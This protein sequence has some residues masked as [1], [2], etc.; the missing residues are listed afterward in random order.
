MKKGAEVKVKVI[1]LDPEGRRINLSLKHFTE[2]PWLRFEEDFHVNDIVRGKVTKLTDFGA[3]IEL[4]EGIEGLAHVSE[5]SWTKKIAN[6][7]DVLKIGDEVDC[8]IL[9]YDIA[10]GRVSLGLKQVTENPWD[11]FAE[12]SP[13]GT[14]LTGT[15]VKLTASGAYVKL[16]CGL[17]A[18][19]HAD[20]YSWTRRLKNL[21]GV[22]NVGDEIETVVLDFDRESRRIRVGVKQLSPDP[23]KAF[24]EAHQPGDSVEGEITSI[25]DFGVFLKVDGDIEGLINKDEYEAHI[26]EHRCPAGV[27]TALTRFEINPDKQKVSF[28]VREYKRRADREEFSRYIS[29]DKEQD[30]D[31]YT[32]FGDILKNRSN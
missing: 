29:S 20:D 23:W 9:G 30:N 15:V 13:P 16:S 31:S 14:R 4:K 12:Q 24:A 6:P 5:F 22:L 28:S 17:D 26:M 2:D 27:C 3:F 18:F 11:S 25:T 8:M 10:A 21:S 1:N 7:A 19:L 32:P